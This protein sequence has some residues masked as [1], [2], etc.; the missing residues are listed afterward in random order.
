MPKKVLSVFT[1]K[2]INFEMLDKHFKDFDE[3][4]V[5]D[6]DKWICT[7]VFNNETPDVIPFFKELAKY[8]SFNASMERDKFDDKYYYIYGSECIIKQHI[9]DNEWNED[10]TMNFI[11]DFFGIGVEIEKIKIE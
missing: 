10:E 3:L 8:G 1:A 5:E 2:K 7:V 6:K 4:K 9:P 11:K